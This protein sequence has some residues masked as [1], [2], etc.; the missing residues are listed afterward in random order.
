MPRLAPNVVIK[1][2]YEPN[3]PFT[4]DKG[5]VECQRESLR[6]ARVFITLDTGNGIAY[7]LNGSAKDF[8]FPDSRAIMKPGTTGVDLQPFIKMGL[9]ICEKQ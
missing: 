6:S 3:W 8:G 4:I 1:Q 2:D 5:T 7:G 9:A